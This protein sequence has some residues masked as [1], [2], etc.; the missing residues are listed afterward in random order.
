LA[1]LVGVG[2]GLALYNSPM[3]WLLAVILLIAAAL[4]YAFLTF[5]FVRIG[6]TRPDPSAQRS[7]G[8]RLIALFAI[9]YVLTRLEPPA[10]WRLLYAVGGGALIGLG[11]FLVLRLEERGR[12]RAAEGAASAGESDDRIEP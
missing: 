9:A 7:H 5:R 2:Y 1:A 10:D 11:G 6:H 8:V 3:T 4:F 12:A